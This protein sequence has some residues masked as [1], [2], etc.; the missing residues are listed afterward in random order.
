MDAL[1]AIIARQAF[2]ADTEARNYQARA[3]R[4][5]A[6]DGRLWKGDIAYHERYDEVPDND[7]GIRV[8]GYTPT[9][10]PADLNEARNK[11]A[12]GIEDVIVGQRRG[13][14]EGIVRTLGASVKPVNTYAELMTKQALDEEKM[15]AETAANAEREKNRQDSAAFLQNI[16]KQ[17]RG[18]APVPAVPP[19]AAAAATTG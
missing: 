5:M 6:H 14:T 15:K 17:S 2:Q 10:N 19:P 12:L 9:T 11:V 1:S 16:I 4:T 7:V 3:W 18:E 13:N 8:A